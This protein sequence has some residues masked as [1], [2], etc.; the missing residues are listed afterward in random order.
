MPSSRG[1]FQ[2]RDWTQVSRIAGGF[3]TVWATREAL[4]FHRQAI[5]CHILD[6][7]CKFVSTFLCLRC[8]SYSNTSMKEGYDS[9]SAWTS[10]FLGIRSWNTRLLLSWSSIDKKEAYL[11]HPHRTQYGSLCLGRATSR[12]IHKGLLTLSCPVFSLKLCWCRLKVLNNFEQRSK[13]LQSCPTL[14][15]YDCSL[16]GSSVYE[17]LPARILEW[18]AMT[19]S[20]RASQL[21]NWT[22][23][24]YVSCIGRHILYH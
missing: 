6:S 7:T 19:S 13:S 11:S 1:S 24:S 14:Q 17:I 2:P 10:A 4:L 22:H 8:D 21:L 16:L 5:L 15:L 9:S 23:V 12:D 3:F 18:F 20:R